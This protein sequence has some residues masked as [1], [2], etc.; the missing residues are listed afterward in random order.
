MKLSYI[1]ISLD[2]EVL[3]I[4]ETKGNLLKVNKGIICG[5]RIVE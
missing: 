3:N 5:T 2:K 1:P 4:L